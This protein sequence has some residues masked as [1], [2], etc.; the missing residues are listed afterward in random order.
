MDITHPDFAPLVSYSTAEN[1]VAEHLSLPLA[2]EIKVTLKVSQNLHAGMGPYLLGAIAGKD[3]GNALKKGFELERAFLADAKLDLS[4]ASQGDGAGGDWADLFSPDF[5]CHYLAYWTTRPD[6]DV[7][8]HALPI[9][10]KHGTPAK[11][12]PPT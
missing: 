2:E 4:G 7:L 11:I 9:L 3:T 10:G 8:F 5:M 1:V 6:Y 12:Q